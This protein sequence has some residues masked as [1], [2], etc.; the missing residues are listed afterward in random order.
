MN[1]NRCVDLNHRYAAGALCCA[2]RG[3]RPDLRKR[4]EKDGAAATHATTPPL[5]DMTDTT[6]IH[7][8]RCYEASK[9]TTTER[10]LAERQQLKQTTKEKELTTEWFS[11]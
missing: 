8:V 6:S 11:R 5:A 7:L 4:A 9:G 2:E 1:D 3:Q 10:L